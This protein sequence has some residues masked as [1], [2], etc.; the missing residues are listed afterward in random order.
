MYR[1]ARID[2]LTGAYNY[3]SFVEREQVLFNECGREGLS[4]LFVDVDD[5]KLFNQL[6]G[7]SAGDE[8]LR[9]IYQQILQCAGDAENVFRSSGKVFAVLLP[10]T[11]TERARQVASAIQSRI[12]RIT[13]DDRYQHMPAAS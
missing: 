12:R 1:E 4:L 11:D 13:L 8:V 2:P 7:A 9:R 10:R 3:R 6:Y 5:F